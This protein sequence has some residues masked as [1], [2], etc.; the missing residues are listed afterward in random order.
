[1][2]EKANTASRSKSLVVDAGPGWELRAFRTA[3]D[4]LALERWERRESTILP[5]EAVPQ[6]AAIVEHREG[7]A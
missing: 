4:D 7:E 1:M 5:G 2:N 6:L 3:D